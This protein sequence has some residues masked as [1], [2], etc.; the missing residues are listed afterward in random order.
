MNYQT[1][2]IQIISEYIA[3][4]PTDRE[5]INALV[6]ITGQRVP[7]K[8]KMRETKLTTTRVSHLSNNHASWTNEQ[9]KYIV[10]LRTENVS[11]GKIAKLLG[12]TSRATRQRWYSIKRRGGV[13]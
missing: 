5:A 10:Q 9:D 11:W 6:S 8:Y 12:R 4:N 2:Q 7:R 3:R 13:Q 1:K